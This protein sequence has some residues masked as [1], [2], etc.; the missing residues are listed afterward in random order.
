MAAWEQAWRDIDLRMA[1][2]TKKLTSFPPARL[3]E[4]WLR[5]GKFV[6]MGDSKHGGAMPPW[7]DPYAAALAADGVQTAE[8]V[9]YVTDETLFAWETEARYPPVVVKKLADLRNVQ[10]DLR[11]N[12][13]HAFGVLAPPGVQIPGVLLKPSTQ[14]AFRRKGVD[15]TSKLR[16]ATDRVLDMVLDDLIAKDLPPFPAH[17]IA[18]EEAAQLLKR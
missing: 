14:E 13:G 18:I 11:L 1:D 3:V 12:P 16:L 10:R 17:W 7:C 5:Q 8:D 15:T 9:E 6:P 4:R 2:I